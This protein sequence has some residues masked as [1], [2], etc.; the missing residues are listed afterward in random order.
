MTMQ[1]PEQLQAQ[2]AALNVLVRESADRV[3]QHG[4]RALRHERRR[5]ERKALTRSLRK[6][7]RVIGQ[8]CRLLP[9]VTVTPPDAPRV[10]RRVAVRPQHPGAP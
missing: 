7:R 5:D 3:L 10:P 6:L 8:P 1:T 4:E 2:L 9:D